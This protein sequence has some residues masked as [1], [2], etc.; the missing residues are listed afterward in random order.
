MN[1]S[2]AEAYTGLKVALLSSK[3]L[4][5]ASAASIQSGNLSDEV[6]TTAH[7]VSILICRFVSKFMNW[8]C[9]GPNVQQLDIDIMELLLTVTVCV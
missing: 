1:G 8:I 4:L 6:E 9:T 2:Y 3:P 7:A 5:D